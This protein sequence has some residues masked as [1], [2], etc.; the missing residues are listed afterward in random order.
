MTEHTIDIVYT[1]GSLALAY[2]LKIIPILALIAAA[3]KILGLNVPPRLT[4][5]LAWSVLP[6][7]CFQFFQK[8]FL[9]DFTA[10]YYA[11]QD[12]LAGRDPYLQQYGPWRSPFVYPPTSQPFVAALCVLPFRLSGTVWVG[13]SMLATL[14]LV[15]FSRRVLNLQG[16]IAGRPIPPEATAG[17]MAAVALSTGSRMGLEYGQ[18]HVALAVLIMGALG[19][20]ALRQPVLAGLLLVPAL[21]KPQTML[22][23]LILFV[24]RLDL[25]TWVTL[26]VVAPLL[27][28]A[29]TPPADLV[30]RYWSWQAVAQGSFDMGGI[31]DLN[32]VSNAPTEISLRHLMYCLGMGDR[33]RL[34]A[35]QSLLVILIGLALLYEIAW[36]GRITRAAGCSLVSCYVMLCIYHRPY[37]AVIL[38]LPLVYAVAAARQSVGT[39]CALFTVAGLAIIAAMNN[40]IGPVTQ[41]LKMSS[42]LGL[43]DRL[44]QALLLPYPTYAVLIALVTLWAAARLQEHPETVAEVEL[45]RRCEPTVH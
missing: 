19:A 44:L 7:L 38:A 25:G 6:V 35:Y 28:V 13:L 34:R 22:P 2:L 36:R 8:Y 30:S 42:G 45:P 3:A 41:L 39:A 43:A 24:R 9:C 10:Y 15:E 11:G 33:D 14:G 17:L 12:V 32:L 26:G 1:V 40:Y 37:D 31:N 16:G 18:I 27:V 5:W 4:R 29:T 21:S 20:Q 23:Y